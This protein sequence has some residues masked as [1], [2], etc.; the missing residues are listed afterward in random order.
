MTFNNQY[1]V[2]SCMTYI[3]YSW[4]TLQSTPQNEIH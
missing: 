4:W 2:T 1:L 3:P